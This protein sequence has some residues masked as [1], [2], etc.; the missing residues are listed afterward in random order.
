MQQAQEIAAQEHKPKTTLIF[1]FIFIP[2]GGWFSLEVWKAEQKKA[3]LQGTEMEGA[4]EVIL[5]V[6]LSQGRISPSQDCLSKCFV[7][8]ILKRKAIKEFP[9]LFHES[10]T[11]ISLALALISFFN[12]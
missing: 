6:H 10:Y 4:L 8:I 1:S 9:H 3:L 7:W 12:V 2:K 11:N 5:P